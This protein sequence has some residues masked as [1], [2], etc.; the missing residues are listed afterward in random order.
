MPT[1]HIASSIF[2]SQ[3]PGSSSIQASLLLDG[4]LNGDCVA[5]PQTKE[6]KD[7]QVIEGHQLLVEVCKQTQL[8]RILIE[9]IECLNPQW[10]QIYNESICHNTNLVNRSAN[11]RAQTVPKG[12]P[13]HL[14]EGSK[15]QMELTRSFGDLLGVDYERPC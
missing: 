11:E 13:R 4:K 14:S 1:K 10:H 9:A 12:R 6:L 8:H 5:K 15:P 3:V 7:E 2:R